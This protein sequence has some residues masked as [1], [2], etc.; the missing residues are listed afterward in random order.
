M[1]FDNS[2]C[3]EDP[4]RLFRMNLTRTVIA[5]RSRSTLM[6]GDDDHDDVVGDGNLQ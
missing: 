3:P 1:V 5:I 2:L 6:I 4:A